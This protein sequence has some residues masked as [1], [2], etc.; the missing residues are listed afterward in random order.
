M[1]L[2]KGQSL[3][4]TS[5]LLCHA[6][7]SAR[8]FV[9]GSSNYREVDGVVSF[10]EIGRGLIVSAEFRGLPTRDS[11]CP[12][13]IF[14]FHIHNGTICSGN[15]EDPFADAD[16]HYNPN[17]CP[18]PAHAGDLPPLFGSRGYAWLAFYTGRFKISDILGKAVIVHRQPDDFTSQPAGNA[19]EKIACGLI[20]S[21]L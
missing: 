3:N 15:A 19:G 1:Y 9:K 5:Y 11:G 2:E 21:I 12:E 10:Y 8:A 4:L 17:Q 6:E 14:G 7:A 16:G 18:H 20:K 13:S